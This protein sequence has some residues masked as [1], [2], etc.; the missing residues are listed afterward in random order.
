VIRGGIEVL[1]I[2][3]LAFSGLTVLDT[4]IFMKTMMRRRAVPAGNVRLA[5]RQAPT[6]SGESLDDLF[7]INLAAVD[8]WVANIAAPSIA[9]ERLAG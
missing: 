1:P 8:G 2:F 7:A 4:S 5:W 3:S 9:A 6:A